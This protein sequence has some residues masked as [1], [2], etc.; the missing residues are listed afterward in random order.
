MPWH[1]TSPASTRQNARRTSKTSSLWSPR[2]PLSIHLFVFVDLMISRCFW[3]PPSLGLAHVCNVSTVNHNHNNKP[4]ASKPCGIQPFP[5]SKR[6][7]VVATSRMYINT[8]VSRHTTAFRPCLLHHALSSHKSR[9]D[10]FSSLYPIFLE[11]RRALARIRG[12]TYTQPWSAL[13]SRGRL[14]NDESL[15]LATSHCHHRQDGWYVSFHPVPSRRYPNCTTAYQ[16]LDPLD[17]I[18]DWVMTE[19]SKAGRRPPASHVSCP[20]LRPFTQYPQ[21]SNPFMY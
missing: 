20:N 7:K 17:L 4:K 2:P 18:Y 21:L 19:Y 9:S 11:A 5:L 12:H 1:V 14:P 3:Q 13:S 15:H 10:I 6:P 16:P 8:S